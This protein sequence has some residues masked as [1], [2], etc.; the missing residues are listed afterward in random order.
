MFAIAIASFSPISV[1]AE[2]GDYK[3]PDITGSIAVSDSDFS[4]LEE[5][6]LADAMTIAQETVEDSNAMWGS[7]KSSKD[8]W[9][10]KLEFYLMMICITK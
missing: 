3:I 2:Y 7:F 1:L 10:T 4:G 6:S 5:I 8:T 9:S